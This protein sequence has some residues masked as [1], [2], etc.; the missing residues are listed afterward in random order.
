MA[1]LR[2]HYTSQND[3]GE[4]WI[5][6]SEVHLKPGGDIDFIIIELARDVILDDKADIIPVSQ[7]SV[8]IGDNVLTAGWGRVD[9]IH[10]PTVLQIAT[11]QVSNVTDGIVRTLV[12][13]DNR[14]VPIDPCAGDSGGPLVIREDSHWK[15]VGTLIG[16]GYDCQTNTTHGDGA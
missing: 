1:I 14:G 13:V 12:N 8:N 10:G 2:D 5:D 16:A 9:N 15:L 11:L 3:T 7:V 4:E 6:I